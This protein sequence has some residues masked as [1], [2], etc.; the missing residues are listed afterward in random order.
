MGDDAPVVE[1]VVESQLAA[2][3]RQAL[4]EFMECYA[5]SVEL[6]IDGVVAASGK[7]ALRE[8]YARQFSVAPV[9]A[10]VVLRIRQAEWIADHELIEG[11]AGGPTMSVLA[12]YRV[13][14][15]LIDQVQ[16]FGQR[17]TE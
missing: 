2:F 8:I 3:N 6:R 14:D 10:D 13:R 7:E 16:F 5:E 17:V 1:R 11:A 9:R 4:D 15:G 12:L